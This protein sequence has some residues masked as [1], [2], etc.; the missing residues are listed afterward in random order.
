MH[1]LRQ[2]FRI[3]FV[4]SSGH[5][6]FEGS[7]DGAIPQRAHGPEVV[8]EF[9]LVGIGR[10]THLPQTI[11]LFLSRPEGDRIVNKSEN[12]LMFPLASEYP[13]MRISLQLKH[14]NRRFKLH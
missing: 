4:G 2:F 10:Q 3:G 12:V 8:H 11:D 5:R 7:D 1:G 6:R 13:T 14:L 9:R